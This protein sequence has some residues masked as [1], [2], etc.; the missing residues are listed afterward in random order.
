MFASAEQVRW[1]RLSYLTMLSWCADVYPVY[2]F[3]EGLVYCMK[4]NVIFFQFGTVG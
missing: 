2:P 3:V 4:L 1:S